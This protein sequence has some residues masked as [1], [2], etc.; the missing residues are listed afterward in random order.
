ML[1]R[2]RMSA[3]TPSVLVTGDLLASCRSC[4]RCVSSSCALQGD[5]TFEHISTTIDAMMVGH[6]DLEVG[7]GVF[8]SRA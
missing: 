8:P 7:D 6:R 4:A 3:L 2:V 5:Y 1:Q